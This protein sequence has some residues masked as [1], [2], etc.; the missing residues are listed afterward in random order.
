MAR[1]GSPAGQ[2]SS[3]RCRCFPSF[4][5][6]CSWTSS[7]PRS[8][9][10]FSS[11]RL[12]RS[13]IRRSFNRALAKLQRIDWVVYAKRPFA[14]PEQV[15]SYLGRYTHRVAI[16]NSRLIAL[17]DGQVSFRWND[18]RHHVKSKVMT[19]TADE[20]IRRFLL[21]TL[22]GG[23]HRIRHYGFLANGHRAA[24][25]TR[26]RQLLRVPPGATAPAP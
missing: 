4:S 15:L 8:A 7:R 1:A 17:A 11:E 9:A 18:Y 25:L 19:L 16:A 20:F 22:P 12:P 26:C 13:P 6:D 21:H 10:C 2:A 23:F 14:G 24:K 5:D 3:S